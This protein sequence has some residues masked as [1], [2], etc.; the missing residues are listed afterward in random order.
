MSDVGRCVTRKSDVGLE[1]QQCQ[2]GVTLLAAEVCR[3]AARGRNDL[4]S[5]SS[6]YPDAGSR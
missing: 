6:S 2:S 3:V 1:V 5:S 4:A